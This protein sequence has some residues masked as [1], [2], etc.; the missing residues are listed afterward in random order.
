VIDRLTLRAMRQSDVVWRSVRIVITCINL[1][2]DK[3]NGVT[4]AVKLNSASQDL[5]ENSI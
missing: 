2:F 5:T 4:T 3:N 1:Q